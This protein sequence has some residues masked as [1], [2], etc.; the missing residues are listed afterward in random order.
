MMNW[1]ACERKVVMD[2]FKVP[3]QPFPCWTEINHEKLQSVIVSTMKHLCGQTDM[4]SPI[5]QRIYNIISQ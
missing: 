2:C 1:K 5:M 3:S 4:A